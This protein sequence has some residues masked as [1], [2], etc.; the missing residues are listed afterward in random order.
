MS[1]RPATDQEIRKWVHRHFG[2]WPE[3][4]WIAHC[5]RLCSLPV[6]DVRLYQQSQFEPLPPGKTIRSDQSPPPFRN[7]S[8]GNMS[9]EI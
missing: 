2:F 9:I 6:E 1:R 8:T 3:A 4:A 7:A 5:K